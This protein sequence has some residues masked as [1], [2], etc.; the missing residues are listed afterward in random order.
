MEPSDLMW[1]TQL[2]RLVLAT[3]LVPSAEA[4]LKQAPPHHP[5]TAHTPTPAG[6]DPEIPVSPGHAS[7]SA[8]IFGGE[9][10]GAI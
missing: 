2:V 6:C 5:T 1:L 3:V 7:A 10:T 9:G 4:T 8:R